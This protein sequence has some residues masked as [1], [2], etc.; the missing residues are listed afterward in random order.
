MRK[1][2][3]IVLGI[4]L[5]GSCAAC[6]TLVDEKETSSKDTSEVEETID[7][8]P[9]PTLE[10]T[11][12]PT[13][14]PAEIFAQ[15]KGIVLP[16]VKG[17]IITDANE[18][19]SLINEQPYWSEIP[20]E[21]FKE[22]GDTYIIWY[23]PDG[24]Y[25]TYTDFLDAGYSAGKWYFE[26]GMMVTESIETISEDLAEDISNTD[27]ESYEQ[28]EDI[29]NDNKATE[30]LVAAELPDGMHLYSCYD[31]GFLEYVPA[32]DEEKLIV[33]TD[34]EA[35]ANIR[36]FLCSATW[37]LV[38]HYDESGNYSHRPN[39]VAYTFLADGQLVVKQ[40]GK[41]IAGHYTLNVGE[42]GFYNLS[43]LLEDGQA[44]YTPLWADNS[45]SYA[46]SIFLYPD[47]LINASDVYMAK[48]KYN[49]SK[50]VTEGEP[51]QKYEPLA[52]SW[53]VRIGDVDLSKDEINVTSPIRVVDEKACVGYMIDALAEF[54]GQSIGDSVEIV[55]AD[56]QTLMV[57]DPS[58]ALLAFHIEG[59][60]LQ[61]PVL[62]LIDK[63]T[64]SESAVV[65]I[66]VD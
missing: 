3:F 50:V 19:Q 64:I 27:E 42:N 2:L 40:D 17:E 26:N 38:G 10:T 13:Q 46:S 1:I 32:S 41:N 4:I 36:Y 28:L 34:T 23:K 8:T 39:N 22:F 58:Q 45:S 57:D 9:E 48:D 44:L 61:A 29:I 11:P 49:I 47:Y 54:A 62:V 56:G 63:N 12:E 31:N 53:S 14:N 66:K 35:V 30:I 20:S 5:V 51:I 25:R 52:A 18:I 16:D 15:E 24:R 60:N 59:V 33:S 21:E 65:E 7:S 55:F 6:S 43:Y 37:L